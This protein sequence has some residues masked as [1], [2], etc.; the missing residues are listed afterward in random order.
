MTKHPSAEWERLAGAALTART[1][2]RAI[3]ARVEA[4]GDPVAVLREIRSAAMR[5]AEVLTR[6]LKAPAVPRAHQS[7][8]PERSVP[9][10]RVDGAGRGE[11]H[12]PPHPWRVGP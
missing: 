9:L 12:L 5:G 8:R 6:A 2:L 10:W 7:A 4:G 1:A 3:I 11:R